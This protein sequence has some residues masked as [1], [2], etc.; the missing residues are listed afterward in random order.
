MKKH[1]EE[2]LGMKVIML[3]DSRM[4]VV[5]V[6]SSGYSLRNKVTKEVI[7]LPLSQI[8]WTKSNLLF[9]IEPDI[10]N[11]IMQL[12]YCNSNI[13]GTVVKVNF[14]HG[15]KYHFTYATKC[16]GLAPFRCFKEIDNTNGVVNICKSDAT[17]LI[18]DCCGKSFPHKDIT[19]YGVSLKDGYK[20]GG[21][22]T[23][24]YN[25]ARSL[26]NLKVQDETVS[27]KRPVVGHH[28]FK[29]F[30]TSELSILNEDIKNISEDIANRFGL[31]IVETHTQIR[32]TAMEYKLTFKL[33]S[34]VEPKPVTNKFKQELNAKMKERG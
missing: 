26:L 27:T 13:D 20:T 4:K 18:C 17:K 11:K 14:K 29:Q 25:V 9:Q 32:P 7:V 24:C 23:K 16:G 34:D 31:C 15:D 22:C 1:H 12:Q 3:D 19:L 8:K 10:S 5:K 6:S 30:G 33:K 21:L 28:E 2:H